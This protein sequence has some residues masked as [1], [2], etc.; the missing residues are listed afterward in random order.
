[1]PLTD[2]EMNRLADLVAQRVLAA[3]GQ[4]VPGPQASPTPPSLV[5]TREAIRSDI[6]WPDPVAIL[7]LAPHPVAGP[8]GYPVAAPGG[9]PVAAPGGYPV[10]A[11]GGYPVAAPGGYPV[12]APGGYPV[13]APGGYPVAPPGGYPVAAPGG[14]PVAAPGELSRRRPGRISGG[15]PGWIPCGASR[16]LSGCSSGWIP[17][18]PSAGISGR[19]SG[20]IPGSLPTTQRGSMGVPEPIQIIRG[21]RDPRSAM[22]PVLAS[23]P[24]VPGICRARAW[25]NTPMG[26]RLRCEAERRSS[27]R[28]PTGGRP[29]RVPASPASFLARAT[30]WPLRHSAPG[31]SARRAPAPPPPATLSH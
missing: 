29:K 31:R 1:M 11:P 20:W 15:C 2:D 26:T 7:W 9:Y 6:L 25:G 23:W 3:L 13:A 4:S 22:G 8:G 14:Y 10:A 18:R 30:G 16:G 28:R 17:G 21:V 24:L 19:S 27:P 12:A 5:R